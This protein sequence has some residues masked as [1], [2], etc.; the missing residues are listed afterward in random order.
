MQR[1]V[2]SI[3]VVTWLS[4]GATA[5][6]GA[7]TTLDGIPLPLTADQAMWKRVQRLDVGTRVKVTVGTSPAVERY[8]VL[9]SETEVVVLNL[10]A[11]N[12]PKRRLLGMAT[13]NPSWIA[14][15][16][17]TTYRDHDLRIGPD[18]VFAGD[19]KL[20]EL[21]QVVERIPRVQITSITRA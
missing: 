18:G 5:S 16:S 14:G 6:V 4:L 9:L 10:T 2:K 11:E 1:L 21:A 7:H 3:A 8:F 19:Q 12:L 15:T 17:K 13:D 20:A